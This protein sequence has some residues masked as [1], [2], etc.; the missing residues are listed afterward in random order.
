VRE[1]L[2]NAVYAGFVTARPDK[3][4][5]IQGKHPACQQLLI[6]ADV[7]EEAVA[8]FCGRLRST[9]RGAPRAADRQ[10]SPTR[11]LSTSP[12]REATSA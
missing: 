5:V 3:E 7:I 4:P 1:M 12:P 10:R 11:S 9:A 6:S 8:D 2:V